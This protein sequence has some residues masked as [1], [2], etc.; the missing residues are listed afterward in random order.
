MENLRRSC[1]DCGSDAIEI[2]MDE[3]KPTY[4]METVR[5]SCGAV[6]TNSFCTTHNAGQAFHSGC[7]QG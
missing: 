7:T 3:N 5:Y 1:I 2:I 6:M 4:K